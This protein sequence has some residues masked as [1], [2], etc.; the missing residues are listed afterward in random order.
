MDNRILIRSIMIKNFRSIRRD[1]IKVS[2]FNVFVGMNDA[3]KSNILKA[4]NLFFRDQ[5]DM[6][7]PFDY[8]RDFSYLY[9]PK[10]KEAKAISI[11]IE[12]KVPDTFS[13][14]GIYVWE[15]M[16]KQ[17]GK[18][19]DEI[20][21]KEGNLP[22]PR[23]RIPTALR[24]IKYRYVPAVK[25]SDYYK[26]LLEDLYKSVAASLN[27]TFSSSV[28]SFSDALASYTKSIT[29][30]VF[31]RLGLSSQ[32]TIPA[33]LGEIF[34][35][36][37]FRTNRSKKGI[38]VPLTARGDGIQA[39][40]IPIILKYI[41]QEDQKSRKQGSTKVTTI[42]GFEE[43]EN[44]LELAN[45]FT[46]ADEFIEY[47]KDL[48]IFVTTYSPAFYMKKEEQ[49][50][51][52]FYVE[53][54][55]NGSEETCITSGKNR[56]KIADEMG[57]MPLVAPFIAEQ[58]RKLELA[59]NI[60]SKNF[61]TDIPTIM[62]EGE[63]DVEYIGL[64][65]RH[66]SPVLQKKLDQQELRIIYK[67]DGAGTTQLC[68]WAAAWIYSGFKSKVYVLLDKD[69]AG[70][71]AREEIINGEV[72]KTRHQA[73]SIKIAN[74]QP[75]NEI[76][77]LHKEHIDFLYEIEHLCSAKVWE[78]WKEQEL[79]RPRD[80]AEMRNMF[81]GLI[82]RNKSLDNVIDELVED[83]EIRDTILTFEPKKLK[84]KQMVAYLKGNF[85]ED[86]S[87]FSGFAR[88]IKDIEKFF[89]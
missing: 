55:E 12:F 77:S 49:G 80:E 34:K 71:K 83:I 61:L 63:T 79:V 51:N 19:L 52:I 65:I 75:S 45:A 46:L 6:N 42:W 22:A 50:V 11:S 44:G 4:L 1:N 37:I 70:R 76:I 87:A 73:L 58:A 26:I 85:G 89:E 82:P 41:A 40:H 47:S 86:T 24:R 15:K 13:D 16:W 53:K 62:V 43:P 84:K 81:D 36:L 2:D 66:L 60:Y 9:P 32:L 69:Y 27:S 31:E 18:V 88:T 30:D 33:D 29:E 10:S 56:A 67:L 48:Q 38:N 3:G 78:G 28:D 7:A 57:L 21:D 8:Q 14:G 5:V 23:S 64:A 74:I 72:Y 17:T 25:S 54:K 59:Q 39:R 20:R 68:D 35:A